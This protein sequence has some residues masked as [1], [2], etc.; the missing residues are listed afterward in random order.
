MKV[1]SQRERSNLRK[2]I[3]ILKNRRAKLKQRKLNERRII[4]DNLPAEN[5]RLVS[6]PSHSDSD[7]SGLLGNSL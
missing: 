7:E 3:E 4:A 1:N 5:D 6:L 2:E